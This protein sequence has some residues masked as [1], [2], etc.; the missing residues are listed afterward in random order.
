MVA[1]FLGGIYAD[2]DTICAKPI[3]DWGVRRDETLVVGVEAQNVDPQG[4]SLHEGAR[5]VL[6]AQYVF[7]SAAFHPGLVRMVQRLV[8]RKE[9]LTAAAAPALSP[10]ERLRNVLATTGPVGFTD[11]LAEYM[12]YSFSRAKRTPDNY[13]NGGELPDMHVFGVAAF[14]AGQT[15]SASPPFTGQDVFVKHIFKGSLVLHGET[16]QQAVA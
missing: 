15:H 1:A 5:T 10:V 12:C 6:F 14:G 16:W 9:E 8:D 11:S 2:S 3:A 4:M 13:Y 7:A